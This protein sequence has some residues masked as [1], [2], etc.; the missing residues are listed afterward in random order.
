MSDSESTQQ[1]PPQRDTQE[2]SSD[3]EP[4]DDA[5]DQPEQ[6]VVEDDSSGTAALN[7]AAASCGAVL[8]DEALRDRLAARWA[9]WG[10]FI[11]SVAAV[12]ALMFSALATFWLGE[13][14]KDQL[15]QTVAAR[16]DQEQSQARL[17]SIWMG[18]DDQNSD[19]YTSYLHVFNRSPDALYEVFVGGYEKPVSEWPK[20]ERDNEA[21]GLKRPDVFWPLV[22]LRPCS[23]Y[24][25][26]VEKYRIYRTLY[27]IFRDSNGKRW[28]KNDRGVLAE[29]DPKRHG[30]FPD[31]DK[32]EPQEITMRPPFGKWGDLPSS[33]CPVTYSP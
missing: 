14:T 23:T 2:G 16:N 25:D 7:E 4:R 32:E 21:E 33:R 29:Y 30:I 3:Q 26:Q 18:P 13:T 20:D 17:L 8:P 15:G 10:T 24:V 6:S 28:V 27:I 9:A 22:T 11:S 31:L 12:A 5:G 1:V 19:E